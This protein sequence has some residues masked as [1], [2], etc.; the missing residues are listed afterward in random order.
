[1]WEG[2]VRGWQERIN[3]AGGLDSKSNFATD[4]LYNVDHFQPLTFSCPNCKMEN[5][6]EHAL[7]STEEHVITHVA[8]PNSQSF[9]SSGKKPDNFYF[10]QFSR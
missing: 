8:R 1:M 6:L 3:G 2:S 7:A 10:Q 4:G 9:S 5:V